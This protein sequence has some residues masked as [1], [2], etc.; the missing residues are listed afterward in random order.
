MWPS[1]TI[2]VVVDDGSLQATDTEK[3]AV[4]TFIAAAKMLCRLLVKLGLELSPN[5]GH[6][7]ATTPKMAKE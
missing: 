7:I 4:R 2:S 3:D 1:L 6:V 5:K